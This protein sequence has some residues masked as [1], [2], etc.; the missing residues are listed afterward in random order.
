MKLTCYI[1]VTLQAFFAHA[2]T[3]E[4]NEIKP[5]ALFSS[6]FWGKPTNRTLIY[7]P[8]E[9]FEEQNSS[10][11]LVRVGSGSLSRKCVYYGKGNIK[12]HQ[13]RNYTEL[14]LDLMEDKSIADETSFFAEVKFKPIP[15]ETQEFIVLFSPT[16]TENYQ[17][18]VVPFSEREIPW[19]SY[20]L[21]SQFNQTLYV[22]VGKKKLSISPGKSTMLNAIDFDGSGRERMIIYQKLN[23]SYKE[24]ASQSFGINDR[25]RGMFFLTTRK[26]RVSIIPMIDNKRPIEQAIGYG[27]KP[28]E[29]VEG[30]DDVSSK[31][32]AALQ[33]F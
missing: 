16:N 21:T 18:Y 20:R 31:T 2:Q 1:L 32:P 13:K 7:A 14:E 3:V 19:G 4:Q 8:W 23:N 17:T 12:F 6:I 15:E 9:N 10:K 29:I 27:T 33:S 5:T 26:K 28:L 22:A 24:V 25:Q 11:S 30:P